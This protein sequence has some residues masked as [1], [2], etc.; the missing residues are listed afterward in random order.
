V[1]EREHVVHEPRDSIFV[2]QPVHRASEHQVP[3]V[4]LGTAIGAEVFG[5]DPG[6]DVHDAGDPVVPLD[7]LGVRAGDRHDPVEPR[8]LSP[9]ESLHAPPLFAEIRA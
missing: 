2:R 7:R 6:G 4:L 1:D 9:L 3:R 5:V 8:A